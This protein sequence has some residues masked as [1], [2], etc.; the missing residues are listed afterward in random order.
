MRSAIRNFLQMESSNGIILMVAAVLAM[1][2]ANSPA[3]DLY[4]G[5]IQLPVEIRIGELEIAKPLFLWINDGLMAI[6]FFVIGLE[7]K[8][9]LMGGELS[10]P[11]NIL[12]PAIGAVGGVVVPVGIYIWINHDDPLAMLGWAIPAAT[13]IAFALGI[14]MMLGTRVPLSLKVFLVSLAI[15]DDLGAIV[16]IAVFY[17]KHL[18]LNAL[19]IASACLV[20]LAFMNYRKVASVSAYLLVGLVMWT[21]VLK[22]GV[23]ATLAGVALAAFIPMTDPD[24]PDRSPLKELEHDLHNVV[25]YGVLP[26]FAFGN[27]G[28]PFAEVTAD[29]FFHGVPLGIM[30]GLF[31]GKQLGIFV[32]CWIAIKLGLAR[33][34]QGATMG[35]LYGVAILCGVGFTMSLFIGTLAFENK[36]VDLDILFDER[37]GVIVG[38]LLSG[39]FGYLVL[40]KALPEEPPP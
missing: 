36:P 27:A 5:F 10:E 13:D 34:P 7:L 23:H 26:L 33:L 24:N 39:V 29:E 19:A 21:S 3:I 15:F 35:G 1:I 37:L 2:A 8:R 32:P 12:L 38:S 25:S 40:R 17:S 31:L 16:I 9:E 11:G 28:I 20:V 4:K 14:L 18:S 6:F 22:S 30:L